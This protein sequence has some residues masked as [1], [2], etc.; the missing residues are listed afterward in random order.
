MLLA[1]SGQ[2]CTLSLRGVSLNIEATAGCFHVKHFWLS[3][4]S[5]SCLEGFCCFTGWLYLGCFKCLLIDQA[6]TQGV[7]M[8]KGTVSN[9]HLSSLHSKCVQALEEKE[10]QTGKPPD[11]VLFYWS[12]PPLFSSRAPRVLFPPRPSV[13]CDCVHL[14]AVSVAGY[15]EGRTHAHHLKGPHHCTAA[16]SCF[17]LS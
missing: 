10:K 12:Q 15:E 17:S 8:G 13:L 9:S 3:R 11:A 1:F 7:R 16:S 4:E 6:W 5:S 2:P 14:C